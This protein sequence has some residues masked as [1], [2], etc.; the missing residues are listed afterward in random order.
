MPRCSNLTSTSGQRS[1]VDSAVDCLFPARSPI[2]LLRLGFE[3]RAALAQRLLDQ[4]APQTRLV[5][6]FDKPG[7]AA[8]AADLARP[9]QR[10]IEQFVG[11][12]LQTVL[13]GE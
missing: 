6:A 2:G 10:V 4:A 1:D 5:V 9:A 12:R 7:N 11:C 8:G 3:L 13:G